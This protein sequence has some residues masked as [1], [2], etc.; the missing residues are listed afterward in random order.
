MSKLLFIL[1]PGVSPDKTIDALYALT[2]CEYS[3]S[4]NTCVI[5]DDKPS[6]MGVSS[7]LKHS[8]DRTVELLKS[9]LEIRLGELLEEWHMSS[10]EKIFIEERIY[11]DIEECETWEGVNC[12]N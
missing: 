4:P 5:V 2:D 8:A 9:E 10:L 3:I 1:F 7:I 11:R 6:F 12:G